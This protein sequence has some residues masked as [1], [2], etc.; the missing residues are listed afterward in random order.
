MAPI[1]EEDTLNPRL[2]LSAQSFGGGTFQDVI[3][4]LLDLLKPGNHVLHA[5][6]HILRLLLPQAFKG[7]LQKIIKPSGPPRN[8]VLNCHP[9]LT[10]V[11]C[12]LRCNR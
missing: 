1:L 7:I 9:A 12:I 5:L 11:D 2:R 10:I 3:Q 8:T 6:Q 4:F